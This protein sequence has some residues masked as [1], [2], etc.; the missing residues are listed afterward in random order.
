MNTA[1]NKNGALDWAEDL[2]PRC[3]GDLFLLDARRHLVTCSAGLEI[4]PVNFFQHDSCLQAYT[5][6]ARFSGEVDGTPYTFRKC[7]AR[8]FLKDSCRRGMQAVMVANRDLQR[9]Y[10]R[11][12]RAGIS[13]NKEFFS[14]Q[15]L[16]IR[17]SSGDEPCCPPVTIIDFVYI[18]REGNLVNVEV[19][20]NRVAA[21]EHY[22]EESVDQVYLMADFAVIAL[23]NTSHCQRCMASFPAE[24]GEDEELAMI[25]VANQRLTSLYTDFAQAGVNYMERFF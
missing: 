8:S 10:R 21:V 19:L 18:A 5:M 13:I 6:F 2:V 16:L 25:R 23:G 20:L 14:L 9:D 22:P 15:D 11:L 7:Y 24:A 4:V 12:S 17:Q 1:A 3:I